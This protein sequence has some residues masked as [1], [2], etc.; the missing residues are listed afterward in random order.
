VRVAVIQTAFLGDL[1]LSVPL[2][3]QLKMQ[4]KCEVSLVAR[5]G[6]GGLLLELGLVDSLHE[7]EKSNRATYAEVAEELN[8]K[9]L[10]HLICL[11]QSFRSGLLA[12]KI[13]V[14][15]K[16]VSFSSWWGGF[17]FHHT[18]P[19]PMHLPDALRQ[20]SLLTLLSENFASTWQQESLQALESSSVN[21]KM[22]DYRGLEIP[23]WANMSVS[24]NLSSSR[25]AQSVLIAPGSVWAT[26][27]WT[28][29]GF[30]GVAAQL[31]REGESVILIGSPA[32]V[33]VCE[34]VMSLALQR[35]GGGSV[36]GRIENRAG[37]DSLLASL[38]I[39]SD[40]KALLSNDS[41]AMHLAALVD[42]PTVAV[43]GPTVL[44][45]GYR[46]WNRQA[47]VVQ[48][49]LNCRPCGK[50]GHKVC[51]IKTHECMASISS[52]EV[53]SALK[54]LLPTISHR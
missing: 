16:K 33:A 43:F 51:P 46:P 1:L 52:A 7:I 42:L 23:D 30:A 44:K 34:E 41:G 50:H 12:K 8:A 18:I 29:Q 54:V 3:K 36:A 10:T 32:E 2:F 37:K 5:K 20:L 38:Q 17:I 28:K 11:H 19:K 49:E 31:M 35:L 22:V 48:K 9:Q 53:V 40:S 24:E 39:M 45:F 27:K 25:P 21:D 15:G 14:S 26:K 6:F 13:R 4:L 47:L